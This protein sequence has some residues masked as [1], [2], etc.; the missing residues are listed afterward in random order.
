MLLSTR[1]LGGCFDETKPLTC[2]ARPYSASP[3]VGYVSLHLEQQRQVIDE[4]LE[5]SQRQAKQ[6]KTA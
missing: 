4:A 5:L 2:V 1:H 6:K 3:A